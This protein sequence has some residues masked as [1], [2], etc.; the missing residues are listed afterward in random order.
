MLYLFT[1]MPK[2]YNKQEKLVCWSF[3][4][5]AFSAL[6]FCCGGERF[7]DILVMWTLRWRSSAS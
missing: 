2:S 6:C 7:G 5:Q 3:R 1:V 4:N